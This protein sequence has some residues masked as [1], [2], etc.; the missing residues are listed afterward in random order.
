MPSMPGAEI[1]VACTPSNAVPPDKTPSMPA[2]ETDLACTPSNAV[3]SDEMP[4]MPAAET[5][6]AC[7][8]SNAVP[9]DEMPSMPAAETDLACPPSNAVPSD[10][11]PSMPAAETDLACPPSN[12]VPSDE[13][14][15]F[16][17]PPPVSFFSVY[18]I[19]E[20][21]L[22]LL[23]TFICM[24]LC[25]GANMKLEIFQKLKKR[26][27]RSCKKI[28]LSPICTSET[29]DLGQVTSDKEQKQKDSLQYA[30]TLELLCKELGEKSNYLF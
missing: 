17:F 11:M 6:L 19:V 12:A 24:H 21:V 3:P 30:L 9:S 18:Y 20:V 28:V 25:I 22:I 16:H 10:E 2:A 14:A 26:R 8:P 15:D 27:R 7:P 13:E 4:S 23:M 5:D 1:E 29:E